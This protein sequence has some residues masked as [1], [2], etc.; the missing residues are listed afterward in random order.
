[1][2]AYTYFEIQITKKKRERE[3][4]LFLKPPLHHAL[5]KFSVKF[6]DERLSLYPSCP[7]LS[8]TVSVFV[9]KYHSVSPAH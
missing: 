9:S 6:L 3:E 5:Y 4:K 2:G 7:Q 8:V 1:M